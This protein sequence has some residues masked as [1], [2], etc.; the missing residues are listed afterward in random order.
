MLVYDDL[1]PR[2]CK[3]Y[4]HVKKAL[5]RWSFVLNHCFLVRNVIDDPLEKRSVGPFPRPNTVDPEIDVS[6]MLKMIH[7][8]DLVSQK[9]VTFEWSTQTQTYYL[10]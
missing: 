2:R 1:D 6:E 9:C 3:L 5:L 7:E 8:D 4:D 10:L